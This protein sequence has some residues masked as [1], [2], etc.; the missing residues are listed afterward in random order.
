MR[1][2]GGGGRG[3]IGGQAGASKAGSTDAYHFVDDA[4]SL[5]H[6]RGLEAHVLH[7]LEEVVDGDG[8]AL[9][10]VEVELLDLLRALGHLLGLDQHRVGGGA[11]GELGGHV[12]CL[13]EQPRLCGRAVSGWMF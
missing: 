11:G 2:G 3:G 10:L 7:A 6:G 5:A 4:D 8:A 13:Y 9:E 12:G 1:V